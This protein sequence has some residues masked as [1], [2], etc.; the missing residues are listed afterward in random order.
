LKTW[1][2][3]NI[4][5]CKEARGEKLFLGIEHIGIYPQLG[6]PSEELTKWYKKAFDFDIAE[7]DSWFFAYSSGTG[8]IEILKDH[9]STKAHLAIKVRHFERACRALQNMGFELEPVKDFGRIK[10]V[11]LKQRDPAGYKIHLLYQALQ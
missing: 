3:D 1:A 10:A 2:S 9:E 7:G 11:F 6:Q 4:W 5:Y 8:R